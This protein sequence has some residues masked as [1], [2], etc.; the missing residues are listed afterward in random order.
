MSTGKQ[1]QFRSLEELKQILIPEK[2]ECQTSADA[3]ENESDVARVYKDKNHKIK[4]ELSFR[5]KNDRS[6]LT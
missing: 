1:L 3:S 4:K 2:E 5:T 6:R